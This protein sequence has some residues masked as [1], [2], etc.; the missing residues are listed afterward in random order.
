MKLKNRY[1]ILFVSFLTGCVSQEELVRMTD[2]CGMGMMGSFNKP[3][4]PLGYTQEEYDYSLCYGIDISQVKEHMKE[5]TKHSEDMPK[6]VI[7]EKPTS[8]K[9]LIDNSNLKF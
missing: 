1:V 3:K 7:V 8:E 5:N 6:K 2:P 9:E 4:P